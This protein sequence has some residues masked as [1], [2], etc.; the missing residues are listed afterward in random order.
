[1]LGQIPLY[2]RV[3]AEILR[4]VALKCDENEEGVDGVN[5]CL[6]EKSC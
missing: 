4:G 5:L 2:L 6:P 1:V 3:M